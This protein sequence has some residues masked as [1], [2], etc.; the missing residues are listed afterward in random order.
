MSSSP[1]TG[2]AVD[3]I[4]RLDEI[5]YPEFTQKLITDTFDAVVSSMIRQQESYADLLEKVAMTVDQFEAENVATDEVD[6]WLTSTFPNPDGKGSVVGT[7]GDP[8]DLSETAATRLDT[9]LGDTASDMGV[10]LPDDGGLDEEDV[11]TIRDVTRRQIARPRMAAM[12]EIVNQGVVRLVVEDGTIETDLE[13]RTE[14]SQLFTQLDTETT[15]TSGGFGGFGNLTGKLFG[16]NLGGNYHKVNVD[17][18]TTDRR[19]DSEAEAE[20]NGHVKLNVRGDYQPLNTPQS[21]GETPTDEA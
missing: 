18:R 13:F 16:I 5:G 21:P 6:A 15:T 8:G 1:E 10:E 17:T 4:A 14:A 2:D 7:P 3:Q 12:R 20:I 11:V 9:L 19:G